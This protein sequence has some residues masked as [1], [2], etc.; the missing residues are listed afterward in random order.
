MNKHYCL[1]CG[2]GTAYEFEKPK[3][4]GSCGT[5]FAGVSQASAP[6][7]K[8][9]P[10][11]RFIN[12]EPTDEENDFIQVSGLE[13]ENVFKAEDLVGSSNAARSPRKSRLKINKK[14]VIKNF[15]ERA[16]SQTKRIDI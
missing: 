8:E 12:P 4:C 6:V 10:K 3:F 14:S 13:R 9:S 2:A 1:A 7:K 5:P 16:A 11:P 15:S